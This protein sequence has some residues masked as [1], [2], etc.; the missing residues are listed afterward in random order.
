MGDR[1]RKSGILDVGGGTYLVYHILNQLKDIF[2]FT[3]T[4]PDTWDSPKPG[5]RVAMDMN[6]QVLKACFSGLL[7]FGCYDWAILRSEVRSALRTM[8]ACCLVDALQSAVYPGS[9]VILSHEDANESALSVGNTHLA[10]LF[11]IENKLLWTPCFKRVYIM[12]FRA[13]L[14]GTSSFVK[15]TRCT[16]LLTGPRT[17]D[18]HTHLNIITQG[19]PAQFCLDPDG[20]HRQQYWDWARRVQYSITLPYW[21]AGGE[22]ALMLEYLGY[23]GRSL[24]PAK[25][26][27]DW[28]E[29]CPGEQRQPLAVMFDVIHEHLGLL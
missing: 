28:S 5:A 11:T 20:S 12:S 2:D 17:Y 25:T 26:S 16:L 27:S 18:R 10:D 19:L 13:L 24:E 7:T 29:I 4:Y 6:P 8:V 15:H 14:A 22:S 3:A 23:V 21:P 1:V 9:V